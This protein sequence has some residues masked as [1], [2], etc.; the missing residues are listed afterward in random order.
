[1]NVHV[2]TSGCWVERGVGTGTAASLPVEAGEQCSHLGR[3][4]QPPRAP[5]ACVTRPLAQ[6][7]GRPDP[8]PARLRRAAGPSDWF[9]PASPVTDELF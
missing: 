1:M 7:S 8:G 2:S 3:E 6:P 9:P 4:P 5:P